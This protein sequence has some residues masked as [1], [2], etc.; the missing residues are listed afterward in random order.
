MNIHTIIINGDNFSDIESFYVEIDWVLTKDLIFKTGYNL[1]AFNDLLRGGFGVYESGE[2]I[3]LVWTNFSKSKK[4]L[5]QRL[6]DILV[7]II[8]DYNDHI[9]FKTVD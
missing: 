7:Q 1:D 2:Q 9:N 8:K 5:G 6:I 4:Y 3:N